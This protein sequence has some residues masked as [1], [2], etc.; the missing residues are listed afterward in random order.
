[1][2]KNHVGSQN[3]VYKLQLFKNAIAVSHVTDDDLI[4]LKKDSPADM[5]RLSAA[6]MEAQ[7]EQNLYLE[8]NNFFNRSPSFNSFIY[9]YNTISVYGYISSCGQKSSTQFTM[10]Q[11]KDDGTD[12]S[13]RDFTGLDC[14]GWVY[15]LYRPDEPYQSRGVHPSGIGID[16]YRTLENLTEEEKSFLRKQAGLSALNFIDP[17]IFGK[18][19]FKNQI[20][21]E[22]IVWNAKLQHFLTSFGYDIAAVVFLKFREKNWLLKSHQYFNTKRYFPG[23]SVELYKWA[24]SDQWSLSP[25]LAFWEQPAEQR[26]DSVKGTLGASFELTA[27]YKYSD[28]VQ[29]FVAA[30]VKDQGW[31]PGNVDLGRSFNLGTGFSLVF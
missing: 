7:I 13:A 21:G 24:F 14:L 28:S 26:Y 2:T 19:D 9:F 27:Y 29:P 4:R 16:R 30:A 6:G 31:K 1:M 20:G 25:E 5:V 11:N 12:V 23:F 17:F 8:K 18:N 10:D 3:D 15:D 22:D